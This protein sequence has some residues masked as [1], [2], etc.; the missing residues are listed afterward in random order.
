MT[1]ETQRGEVEVID[2]EINNADKVIVTDLVLQTL[3]EKRCLIP[4][5]ALDETR[6][7]NLP[8]IRKRSISRS[9]DT[10]SAGRPALSSPSQTRSQFVS[11]TTKTRVE[12]A[13]VET[14]GVAVRHPSDVVTYTTLC[15]AFRTPILP[16]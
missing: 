12:K 14:L 6:H 4:V 10:P 15:G 7:A 1:L 2:K 13:L 3:W 9:F 8:A 11:A 16:R 5:H